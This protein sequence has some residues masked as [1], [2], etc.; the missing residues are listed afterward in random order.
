LPGSF[1]I[2]THD[3]TG[4]SG[5]WVGGDGHFKGWEINDTLILLFQAGRN[6]I[7]RHPEEALRSLNDAIH[8]GEKALDESRDAIQ[9]SRSALIAKRMS[10]SW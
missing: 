10:G 6:L 4:A 9:G 7:P 3:V 5:L 8:L 2:F 1:S